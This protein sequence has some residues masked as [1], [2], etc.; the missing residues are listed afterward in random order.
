MSQEPTVLDYVKALLTPWRGAPP[1]IPPVNEEGRVDIGYGSDVDLER[2][3]LQ[4]GY[5]PS[6]DKLGTI[7][8]VVTGVTSVPWRTF[9]ALGL[10]LVAQLSLEPG[11][12]STWGLGLGLYILA[13]AM[14]IWANLRGEWQLP[15]YPTVIKLIDHYSIR[16]VYLWIGVISAVLAFLTFGGNRFTLLNTVLWLFAI[17]F[18]ILALWLPVSMQESWW[19][20]FQQKFSDRGLEIRPPG[21][22]H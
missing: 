18:T 16:Q 9:G 4:E 8:E 1:A 3:P 15:L 5:E 10:G 2:T 17:V 22:L 20:K 12:G 7:D 21:F 19:S 14:A 6:T 11:P 13:A